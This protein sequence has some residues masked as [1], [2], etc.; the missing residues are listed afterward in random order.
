MSIRIIR[1]AADKSIDAISIGPVGFDDDRREFLFFDQP[2]RDRG[3][4]GV[5]I[6]SAVRS[7]ADQHKSAV[8]N[9]VE[10]RHVIL[11]SARQLG[12]LAAD[13]LSQRGIEGD[14]DSSPFILIDPVL[15][16]SK[17]P[18]LLKQL[19]NLGIAGLLEVFLPLA[20]RGKIRRFT[21]ADDYIAQMQRAPRRAHHLCCIYKS[22]TIKF[23]C[24][25][26]GPIQ[27]FCITR[28]RRI[29]AFYDR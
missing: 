28:R 25:I 19:V 20:D 10:K 6:V 9:Q 22:V 18:A 4:G 26:P 2:A 15:L 5:K 27:R 11:R 14:H 23:L 24:D 29:V 16:R 21:C 17:I 12:C 3:A 7:F 13:R 1:E 8:S